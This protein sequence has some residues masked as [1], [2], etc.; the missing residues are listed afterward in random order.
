M[1]KALAALAA[2][3]IAGPAFADHRQFDI[4]DNTFIPSARIGIDIWPRGEQPSVPHS[5]HGIEIG[6]TGTSGEDS[7]T[8]RAGAPT[9]TFGGQPFAAPT[10]TTLN[11]DF[12]FRFF[13]LAYRFRHFFGASRAF[14]IEALGGLGWAE[15]DLAVSSATQS[16]R[17]KLQSGGLVAGFGIIWKFLPQTSLQSRLTL[18]G[19]GE[20]EGVSGAGRADVYVVHALGRNAAVRAGLTSWGLVSNR[21]EDDHFSSLNSEIRARFSGISL[22]LDLAF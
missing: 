5:G 20:S 11:Y 19:S 7:Q 15:L 9:L 4:E 1:K 6:Y 12:D 22:G 16:A 3:L 17:E 13:E 21:E 18:F 2:A 14:G 8:R 10:T